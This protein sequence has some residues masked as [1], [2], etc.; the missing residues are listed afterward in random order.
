MARDKFLVVNSRSKKTG[1]VRVSVQ[2]IYDVLP[3]RIAVDWHQAFQ[4]FANGY[5]A[6]TNTY[7]ASGV[8]RL[9][10]KDS[11]STVCPR[12]P[13]VEG[14]ASSAIKNLRRLHFEKGLVKGR[15][16]STLNGQWG[17]FIGLLA[18]AARA[19]LFPRLCFDSYA[20][21]ALP[22]RKILVTRNSARTLNDLALAPRNLNHEADSYNEDLLLPLSLHLSDDEYLGKYER[23]LEYAIESFR[24]CALADF[25]FQKTLY[26]EGQRLIQRTD[27]SRLKAILN[28][29]RNKG[30]ALKIGQVS[31]YIDTNTNKH[32]LDPADRHPNL[33]G[34][35]LA[36]VVNE[37]AG[38]PRA[39]QDQRAHAVTGPYHWFYVS[40]YGKHALLPY[41]GL[42]TPES[43]IAMVVLL[44]LEHPSINV[45]SLLNADLLDE[46][47]RTILLSSAGDQNDVRLTVEK[48]RAGRQKH[49][50]LTDI[51]YEVLSWA[52]ARTK[53]IRDLLRAQGRVAEARKLWVGISR[54]SFK[55]QAFTVVSLRTAF[56]RP[57][58]N[59]VGGLKKS[60]RQS[61]FLE[62]H[63]QLSA[64]REHATLKSL[65]VSQGVLQWF[66]TDGDLAHAAQAFGHRQLRTTIENYIPQ[67][68]MDA[69][70]ERQVRR[71]QNLMIAAATG[72][73]PYLLEATDFNSYEELHHFIGS[74]LSPKSQGNVDAED[75]L[76]SRVQKILCPEHR[77]GSNKSQTQ[78]TARVL[79][80]NDP[81]TLAVALLYRE[82]L[83]RAPSEILDRSDTATRTSPRMWLDLMS[84]IQ[85]DLP[86]A[87]YELRELVASATDVADKLRGQIRFP[88]FG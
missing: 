42:L 16:L 8:L 26:Q 29:P 3:H 30:G 46:N 70:Y 53:S 81:N 17:A 13:I 28:R 31:G 87:L 78:A 48:P 11:D 19:G 41:L 76:L 73:R 37:M 62:R 56:R 75:T 61:T 84:T 63:A 79:L 6:H 65:R 80:K 20:F 57:P 15:S 27:Y 24:D 32:I 9:W 12:P 1:Q 52:L 35:V 21:S 88:S 72:G 25:N 64:W 23:G 49:A 85:F 50:V 58:S 77:S 44:L 14:S 5:S 54:A 40:K 36:I 45:E 2:F 82:H 7:G 71:H 4:R 74:L 34:N 38:I 86:D 39:Y 55:P 47:D 33:L 60:S 66:R 43:T 83:L 22:K 59:R 67:P 69:M 18:Q 10:L 51:S 68:V